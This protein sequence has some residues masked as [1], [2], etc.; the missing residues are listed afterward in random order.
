MAA[1]AGTEYVGGGTWQYNADNSTNYSNYYHGSKL[2]R[3]SV[4]NRY[5]LVRSGDKPG[6]VWAMAS[7]A[8]ALTNNQAFWY[9]Y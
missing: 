7:Q 4:Q 5:G 9:V 6:G 8:V 3:S 1:N 2:H